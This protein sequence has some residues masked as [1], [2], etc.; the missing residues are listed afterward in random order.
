MFAA[1]ACSLG[2]SRSAA[3]DGGA[4]AWLKI[5]KSADGP[6]LRCQSHEA[7]RNAAVQAKSQVGI[8]D[9]VLH[10]T[11]KLR[12]VRSPTHI[13]SDWQPPYAHSHPSPE[14]TQVHSPTIMKTLAHMLHESWTEL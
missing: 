7:V 5:A 6:A 12:V 2:S 3:K 4:S 1:Q 14:K 11:A 8:Q 13:L 9:A 10:Q